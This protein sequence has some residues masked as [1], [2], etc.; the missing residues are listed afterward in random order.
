MN[1]DLANILL[2]GLGEMEE[3]ILE[4]LACLPLAGI[5]VCVGFL[6]NWE[7]AY[8]P[9]VIFLLLV[10]SLF[11]LDLYI[12]EINSQDTKPKSIIYSSPVI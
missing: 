12:V 1:L 10:V 11:Q 2:L 8:Y 5:K 7:E 6:L 4:I 9:N 3:R